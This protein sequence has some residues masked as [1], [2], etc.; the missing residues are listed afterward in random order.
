M[1]LKENLELLELKYDLHISHLFHIFFFTPSH[2]CGCFSSFSLSLLS[3]VFP[4][5]EA[6][7]SGE[8]GAPGP[9][10]GVCT[11]ANPDH[12]APFQCQTFT[13]QCKGKSELFQNLQ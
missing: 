10:V 11:A 3:F 5:G 2:V 12:T 4:Q 9:M 7:S 13:S 1:V 6:G 8:S